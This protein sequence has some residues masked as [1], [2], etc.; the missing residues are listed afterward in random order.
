MKR[1]MITAM[2]AGVAL[3]ASSANALTLV[4]TTE[5]DGLDIVV[6]IGV[7]ST[8]AD[9]SS[10]YAVNLDFDIGVGSVL[11]VTPGFD[12]GYDIAS[13]PFC[14]NGVPQCLGA[15][16]AQVF[17]A[18]VV[19]PDSISDFV[20]SGLSIG[21][22][23]NFSLLASNVPGGTTLP[24]D[25]SFTVVPEPTTAGMLGLGLLGLAAGGRRR[26]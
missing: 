1:V 15:N 21:D 20:I 12:D 8:P 3:L 11:A 23:V 9:L 6:H 22:T 16:G 10:G 19:I 4:E 13:A 17:S 14:N 5:Q 2:I 18:A 25:W 26:S 24:E 7:L